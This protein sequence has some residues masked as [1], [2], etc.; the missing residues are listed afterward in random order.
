[1][2]LTRKEKCGLA[3]ALGIILLKTRSPY[4]TT[5]VIYK[6]LEF[7]DV[8]NMD[9]INNIMHYVDTATP[10]DLYNICYKYYLKSFKKYQLNKEERKAYSKA[11]YQ[12]NKEKLKEY[13]RQYSKAHYIHKKKGKK[14]L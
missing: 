9:E 4:T 10:E 5:T 6:A 1:M 11:Y 7:S 14:K 8:L 3:R 12:K 13:K 2:Y